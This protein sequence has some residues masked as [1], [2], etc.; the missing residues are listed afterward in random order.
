MQFFERSAFFVVDASVF[1]VFLYLI[2]LIALTM[3]FYYNMWQIQF[4]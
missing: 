2:K 4:K 3:Y 1:D